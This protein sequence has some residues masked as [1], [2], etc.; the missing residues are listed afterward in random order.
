VW[1][2]SDEDATSMLAIARVVLIVQ[3]DRRAKM[4]IAFKTRYLG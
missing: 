2:V 3:N 1:N 4:K